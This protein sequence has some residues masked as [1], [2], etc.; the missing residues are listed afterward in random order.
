MSDGVIVDDKIEGIGDG[1]LASG[2]DA[3]GI[4]AVVTAD[5][6]QSRQPRWQSFGGMR[7]RGDEQ[8]WL[9]LTLWT[10]NYLL[11][12]TCRRQINF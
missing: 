11:P 9:I 8:F 7:F 3:I 1:W 6:A 2:G 5:F 12:N 4:L 10:P